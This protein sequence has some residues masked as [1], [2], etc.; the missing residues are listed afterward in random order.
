MYIHRS[1]LFLIILSLLYS[2]LFSQ[3]IIN[4]APTPAQLV[5]N[6]LV[7]N[8]ITTSNISYTGGVASRGSFTN[9]STTNLGLNNGIILSTSLVN[10][11][12][13][14]ASYLMSNDLGLSG[15]ADLNA[16]NNGCLTYDA[17]VLS[18]DFIPMSDTVKFR[19]V[20]ASEEYPN[21]VCSQY[22]D[23]FAFF[24]TGPNPS[25]GNYSN[26]NIAKI[27]GTNLPVSVNSVNIGTPGGSYNASGCTS[28]SY[29]NYYVDN[30]SVAG[31][32]IAFNGFTKPLTAWC[33]VIP[34][35]T[36][37]I[38]LAVA[39]GYNGLYDSGVFLEANSFISNTYHVNTYYL[40]SSSNSAIEGCAQGV[41]SFVLSS[42][43]TSPYLINYTVSGSASNGI[44]YP[45]IPNSIT[46]PTG[47]DSAS[48]VINPIFD[49]LPEGTETVIITYTN[50]C[51]PQTDTIY[52]AD[53]TLLQA[54]TGNDT[55]IC[56]G[57]TATLMATI[58]G[59][60]PPFTYSWSNGVT[61]SNPINVTPTIT[62]TYIVTITDNCSSTAT[63]SV[64]VTMNSLAATTSV[65][66]E[67]CGQSNGSVTANA[68]ATCLSGLTYQWNTIPSA[69]TQT[70]NNL[71]SG[72]YSVTVSCGTCSTTASAT[73]INN[74]GPSINVSSVISSNCGQSDGS[75]TIEA[76]GGHQ[77][78]QY[79]W[80]T[81][82]VQT[83][84]LLQN[85]P[86]GS[87]SVT[88]TDSNGCTA[89]QLVTINNISE[90]L[91]TVASST[92][93]HCGQPDGSVTIN[94]TGGNGSYAYMWNTIPAQTTQQLQNVGLGSYIV[95][96]SDALGCTGTMGVNVSEYQSPVA[97]FTAD[98]SVTFTDNNISFFNF[99]TNSTL[100]SW[101]FNDGTSSID[102][103]PTHSYQLPGKY[104][105][106]LYA[107]NNFNCID[108]TSREII[109]N[110]NVTFYIPNTF[111]PDNDG[112]NDLFGPKG[113]GLNNDLF[114]MYIF[115]RWGGIIFYTTDI[116]I[117]WNGK[118]T[119]SDSFCPQGVYTWVVLLRIHGGTEHVTRYTGTVTL[120]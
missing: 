97:S 91:I 52:I 39:D 80:N 30:A 8:G 116:N 46:I 55:I 101:N 4:T 103:N 81:S 84:A 41:F 87:Y 54:T 3:L 71:Q 25:G 17:C 20:F 59:G 49:G 96:V 93:A 104:L 70:V 75:A 6:T 72:V 53:Y 74:P 51:T 37:H 92:E 105:V 65:T 15:D 16:I 57:G 88:V 44:D 2:P 5:Q 98:P 9:G 114:E 94:T 112:I 67:F 111:T 33:H 79:A 10:L 95:T 48:I 32:D 1:S 27:P 11:I 42:P 58:A 107:Q 85:V 21:F 43:A 106:W 35:Q 78:Y 68:S 117:L 113:V 23:V 90:L 19:Y 18:F 50:G 22:N 45:T 14:P 83:N 24:V 86:A 63:S 109:V 13:N 36:Y 64:L 66:D 115:N 61:G 77:P 40:N 110:E 34:C 26:Y 82:P 100:Y 119:N 120:L 118:T 31:T 28:L 7:G 108:S 73:I 99:S 12:V 102:Q 62:T 69:T 29:A 56:S 76:T 47:Q 89:S 38:K 60:N